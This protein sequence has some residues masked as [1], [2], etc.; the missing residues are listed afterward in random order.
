MSSCAQLAACN[1]GRL[2]ESA[3]TGAWVWSVVFDSG[4]GKHMESVREQGPAGAHFALLLA[5]RWLKTIEFDQTF[6]I[7]LKESVTSGTHPNEVV[8][9]ETIAAGPFPSS[10]FKGLVARSA[11]PEGLNIHRLV[12]LQSLPDRPFRVLL[13]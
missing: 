2:P 3:R 9:F 1:G 6:L 13:A 7:S 10:S 4:T 8:Q 5:A 11:S 12:K